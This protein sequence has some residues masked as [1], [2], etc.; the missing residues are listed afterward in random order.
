MLIPRV[1]CD[2]GNLFSTIK[3]LGPMQRIQ[4]PPPPPRIQGMVGHV[5]GWVWAGLETKL[6]VGKKIL[7]STVQWLP[8]KNDGHL[9]LKGKKEGTAQTYPRK[10]EK[11]RSVLELQKAAKGKLKLLTGPQGHG[12]QA[13]LPGFRTWLVADSK[14][15]CFG[16][17]TL[18]RG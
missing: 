4:F 1:H 11:R 9:K 5:S 2:R 10:P 3:Y 18:W 14:G 17:V 8:S 13:N 12:S 16:V 6:Q 7:L 15:L